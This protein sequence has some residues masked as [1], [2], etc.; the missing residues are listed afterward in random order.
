ML[1]GRWATTFSVVVLDGNVKKKSSELARFYFSF[2]SVCHLRWKLPK[3]KTIKK[4]QKY[5]KASSEFF[6]MPQGCLEN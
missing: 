5:K 4:S 2:L 1:F 6:D 3:L